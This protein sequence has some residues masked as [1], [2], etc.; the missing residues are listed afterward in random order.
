M[1]VGLLAGG[2]HG[3]WLP[4][5]LRHLGCALGTDTAPEICG[6]PDL[7]PPSPTLVSKA[8][9][10]HT[11]STYETMPFDAQPRPSLRDAA[12]TSITA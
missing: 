4:L 10:M 2:R 6:R 8:D 11:V 3:L 7:R 5:T 1:D 12:F 9:P